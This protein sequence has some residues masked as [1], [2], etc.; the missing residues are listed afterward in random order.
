MR[1]VRR[2]IHL[3]SDRCIGCSEC[4]RICGDVFVLDRRSGLCRVLAPFAGPA[5]GVQEAIDSCPSDALR[6]ARLPG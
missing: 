3:D 5:A 1:K 2:R 6:W 4:E